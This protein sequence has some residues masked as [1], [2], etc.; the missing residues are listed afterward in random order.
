M[1]KENK[2]KEQEEKALSGYEADW[3]YLSNIK[4][5][6]R[7]KKMPDLISAIVAHIKESIKKKDFEFVRQE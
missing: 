6:Y 1:A 3:L 7:Y 2:S 5:K 4:K